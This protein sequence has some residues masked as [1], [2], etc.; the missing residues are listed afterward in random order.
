MAT[1]VG[2]A[3]FAALAEY[4]AGIVAWAAGDPAAQSHLETAVEC[5]GAAV[6]P[7]EQARTR[8][9]LARVLASAE[10]ELAVSELQAARKEFQR[11]GAAHDVDAAAQQLRRFGYS[12]RNTVRPAGPLTARE[13]EVLELIAEGYSNTRI[14][15]RLFI[16]KRTVEHH[17]SSIL[18]ALGLRSRAEVQAYANGR[19]NK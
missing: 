14:A 6:L 13:S 1:S 2:T 10:P 9:A 16:S 15:A 5:Y 18:A 4:A 11:L 3:Q 12:S 8:L 7:L 17:V 19:L